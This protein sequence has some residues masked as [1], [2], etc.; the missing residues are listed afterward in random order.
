MCLLP[1]L[2]VVGYQLIILRL[3]YNLMGDMLMSIG[4]DVMTIKEIRSAAGLTQ[5]EMAEKLHIPKRTLENWDE[6]KR[7]PPNYIVE[8]IQYRLLG[9]LK[10]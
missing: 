8:L 4:V 7:T 5:A 3:T 2:E 10:K 6:G 9:M 1:P